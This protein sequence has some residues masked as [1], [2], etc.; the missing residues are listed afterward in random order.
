MLPTPYTAQLER[1]QAGAETPHGYSADT[2]LPAEP[3]PVTAGAPG[4]SQEA[5]QEGR[6]TSMVEWTLYLPAGAQIGPQDRV[7]WLGELFAVHGEPQDWTRGPWQHPAAGVVV[8]LRRW[9]G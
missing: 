3:L 7:T 5:R 2:Y 1:W 9:E 4:A 6:D 8:E